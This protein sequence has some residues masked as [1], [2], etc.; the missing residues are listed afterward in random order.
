MVH[1][2]YLLAEVVFSDAHSKGLSFR[3]AFSKS[4]PFD[5]FV[6][7]VTVGHIWRLPWSILSPA[8]L[9]PILMILIYCFWATL[10]TKHDETHSR[11]FAT[12][13]WQRLAA[14]KSP[15]NYCQTSDF[16]WYWDE[17]LWF[18][19]ISGQSQII[20]IP[21]LS[22][23]DGL[24]RALFRYDCVASMDYISITVVIRQF[25]IL[26]ITKDIP[27]ESHKSNI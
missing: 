27:F 25:Y 8:I 2:L 6:I 23:S 26:Q 18:D 19:E 15:K 7:S 10:A 4:H 11:T 21:Q 24:L 16:S 22:H 14:K 12:V 17:I 5:C 13:S 1:S 20:N 9:N 3:F